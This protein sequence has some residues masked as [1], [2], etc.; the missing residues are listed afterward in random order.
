[1]CVCVH[2]SQVGGVDL[3]ALPIIKDAVRLGLKMVGERVCTFVVTWCVWGG[4]ELPACLPA[5][6]HADGAADCDRYLLLPQ[7]MEQLL[8]LP[9]AMTFPIMPNFGLPLPPK[10]ALNV[11]L[12]NG[13][14]LKVTLC[15][16]VL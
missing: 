2:L 9:N 10:G 13:E 7:A 3:M 14:G 6:L 4:W 11:K 1:M 8:V 12:L 5:C 16:A 15:C